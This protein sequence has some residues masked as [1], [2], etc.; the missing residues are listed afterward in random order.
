[1]RA[2]YESSPNQ[3]K[4]PLISGH[5][6]GEGLKAEKAVE[7]HWVSH[8]RDRR[9]IAAFYFNSTCVVGIPVLSDVPEGHVLSDVLSRQPTLCF[10]DITNRSTLMKNSGYVVEVRGSVQ[11]VVTLRGSAGDLMG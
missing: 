9:H 6:K 3:Y 11:S 5:V 2:P 4:S 8:Y 1:M 10:S 7:S